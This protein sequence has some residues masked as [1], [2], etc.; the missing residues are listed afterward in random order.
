MR[1]GT[2]FHTADNT[3]LKCP[4]A[5][6]KYNYGTYMR[7]K[8]ILICI[9]VIG[10]VVSGVFVITSNSSRIQTIFATVIGGLINIIVWLVTS[11]VTD[12]MNHQR[13]EL[14]HLISVID[15]HISMIHKDVIMEDPVSYTI[16][17]MPRS[18]LKTRFL[19]LL[20][21]CINLKGDSD[22]DTT[23]LKL[24]WENKSY[25]LEDFCTEFEMSLAS[26]RIIL[27]E[28]HGK[29]IEWNFDYLNSELIRLRDKMIRYKAYIS[30][31][32]PPASFE[33]WNAK[34]NKN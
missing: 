25:S 18:N 26:H 16:R 23:N 21:V 22:I 1:N 28:Q 27:N 20:Q 4:S 17:T 33:E 5:S 7:S 6:Y 12:K 19:W 3:V 32:K 9:A 11:F 10:I 2:V 24:S 14:D 8:V 30:S 31:K 34:H 13:D 29:M 15:H